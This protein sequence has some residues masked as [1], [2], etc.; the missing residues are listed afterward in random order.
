MVHVPNTDRCD[1]CEEYDGKKWKKLESTEDGERDHEDHSAKKN[2]MTD[3][4]KRDKVGN[5]A[6]LITFDL[7][8][9]VT[10]S[11]Q[12]IFFQEETVL[13]QH[14]GLWCSG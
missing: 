14:M 8:Y 6:Y 1:K 12:F 11:S 2:V 5:D 9:V 4:E 10:L 7:E 13:V 3:E